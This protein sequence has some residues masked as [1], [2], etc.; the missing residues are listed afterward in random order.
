MFSKSKVVQSEVGS[1][2]SIN[3]S[4]CALVLIKEEKHVKQII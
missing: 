1:F 3:V 4:E 2:S